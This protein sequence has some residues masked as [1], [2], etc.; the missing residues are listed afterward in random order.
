MHG[1]LMEDLPPLT[2]KDMRNIRKDFDK[3]FYA[4]FSPD[5]PE[6]DEESMK[7]LKKSYMTS[8]IYARRMAKKKFTPKKYRHGGY[9]DNQEIGK[10]MD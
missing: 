1:K 10:W 3:T 4:R 7:L 8:M 2:K 6:L 9:W 5:D